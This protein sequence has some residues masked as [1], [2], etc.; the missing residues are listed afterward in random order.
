MVAGVQLH[1][2]LRGPNFHHATRLRIFGPRR[3]AQFA[4]CA[5]DDEAVVETF[6]GCILLNIFPDRRGRTEIEP[7][8]GNV[9][10]LSGRN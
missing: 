2:R 1:R 3:L 6:G 10:D 8:A 4:G 7:G 9:V 5:A